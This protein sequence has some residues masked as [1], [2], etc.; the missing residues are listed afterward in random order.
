[1]QSLVVNVG[2]LV[3]VGA[4]LVVACWWYWH[5]LF[6]FWFGI[7]PPLG[8]GAHG[9]L[10]FVILFLATVSGMAGVTMLVWA[11]FAIAFLADPARP[12]KE[13][14]VIAMMIGVAGGI[15]LSIAEFFWQ[16]HR[17]RLLIELACPRCGEC[18][19]PLRGLKVRGGTVRCPECGALQDV[20]DAC[21]RL[22]HR[23]RTLDASSRWS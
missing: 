4:F 19:Y 14:G 1:M 3:A 7:G 20:R 21:E 17:V 15:G 10:G 8:R 13:C 9:L 18:D 2:L 22:R 6:G 11:C 5:R 12:A 23:R 16:R